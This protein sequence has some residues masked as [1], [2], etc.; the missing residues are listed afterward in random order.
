MT[1]NQNRSTAKITRNCQAVPDQERSD[2]L[3]VKKG[4][5]TQR[6]KGNDLCDC[7][8]RA[9]DLPAAVKNAANKLAILFCN[10]IQLPG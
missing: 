10:K 6:S 9:K 3:P 8:M 7:A 4:L 2:A 5:Y 1:G